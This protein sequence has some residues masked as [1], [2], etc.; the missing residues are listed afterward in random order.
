MWCCVLGQRH[1]SAA[2]ADLLKATLAGSA[3]S[4][5]STAH[6]SG[7]CGSLL[8]SHQTTLLAQRAISSECCKMR[9]TR[10]STLRPPLE[11]AR[12]DRTIIPSNRSR[13][14]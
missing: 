6:A 3:A 4:S 13:T 14:C 11:V 5:S 1:S 9:S 2:E 12:G 8:S 10:K 7:S